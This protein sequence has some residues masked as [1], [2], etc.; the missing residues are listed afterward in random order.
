MFD[1]T[2]FLNAGMALLAAAVILWLLS[3]MKNDVSIVDSFWSLMIL[4]AGLVYFSAITET[5]ERGHLVTVLVFLWAVRL[6]AFISWRNWQE[7]EDYRY[8]QIRENNEPHFKY[9]SF[10]IVFAL[11]A[12]LGWLVSLPLLAAINSQNPI[13]WLDYIALLLWLIGMFF[14][15]IGDYQLARFKADSS[16]KGKVMSQGLWRYT[17]HPNYFGEFCIWWGFFVFAVAAGGWWSI[18]SPLLMSLLLLKVSGVSLLEKDITGRRPDYAEYK[19]STNTFFPWRPKSSNDS[20]HNA[21]L[22][23]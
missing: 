23:K 17:R 9:K 2:I 8:Q 11:Q 21:R 16:N 12:F 4:L 14:E 10:Y 3:I 20:I 6:S 18:I 22:T 5:V 13:N 1:L 15:V 7:D 19:A